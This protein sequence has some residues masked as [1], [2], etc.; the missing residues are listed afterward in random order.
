MATRTSAVQSTT[1]PNTSSALPRPKKTSSAPSF[2]QGGLAS[3]QAASSLL[4][5]AERFP[6][7]GESRAFLNL[8]AELVA[9]SKGGANPIS[10]GAGS[11]EDLFADISYLGRTLGSFGQ[12][13]AV[14]QAIGITTGENA[15]MGFYAA[16]KAGKRYRAAERI[17]DFGGKLEGGLD[18]ARGV[19]QGI[20][21][22]FYLGYRG[23]MIASEIANVDAT[24]S[25]TT[26]LGK[27]TFIIGVIGNIFFTVFYLF[28]GLWG[29][30]QLYRTRKM[31]AQIDQNSNVSELASFLL[32]KAHADTHVQLDKVRAMGPKRQKL[33]K[34]EL[35]EKCLNAFADQFILW[36]EKLKG[37][38]KLAEDDALVHFQMKDLVQEFFDQIDQDPGAKRA[39]LEHYCEQLGLDPD[40]IADLNFSSA[41]ICGLKLEEKDRQMR[42]EAR[43]G[44][45]MGGRAVQEIKDAHRKGLGERLLS[46]NLDVQNAA[47]AEAAALEETVRSSLVKNSLIY[48]DLLLIGV[49]G[50][51]VSVALIGFFA[52]PPG[53]A[54]AMTGLSIVLI[55][56]MMGVD[57]YSWLSGLESEAPG[58]HDKL[59]VGGITTVLVGALVLAACLTFVGVGF[60]LMPFIFTMAIGIAGLGVC[61]YTLVKLHL[62]EK[63]WKEEHPDLERFAEKL[64]N[65]GLDRQDQRLDERTA[66]LFKKL[67]KGDRLAIRKEYLAKKTELNFSAA[68]IATYIEGAL[69]RDPTAEADQVSAE[70]RVLERAAKKTAKAFWDK[71]HHSHQKIDQQRALKMY[72]LIEALKVQGEEALSRQRLIMKSIQEDPTLYEAF[73]ENVFYV[74][75]REESAQDLKNVVDSVRGAS[76][77]ASQGDSRSRA[78]SLPDDCL[79]RVQKILQIYLDASVWQCIA[80]QR[81]VNF[82]CIEFFSPF[83]RFSILGIMSA[84]PR[85]CCAEE[86]A[87]CACGLLLTPWALKD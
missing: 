82:F 43:L 34:E 31:V 11:A 20:G 65:L 56:A 12:S 71:W 52:L 19:A 68:Y 1:G 60:P 25:A 76:Q 29:G 53:W 13:S 16:F 14:Y 57:G 22:A 58:K 62:R 80:K 50:V 27:T 74:S 2:F 63:K 18:V 9:L 85:L 44:R 30:Y 67:S 83:F 38:G 70:Y 46:N 40:A 79:E 49:L 78:P 10:G 42:K 3:G 17:G 8:L 61:I 7:P 54:L 47:K 64:D 15:F 81:R 77:A 48:F 39:Y 28:L 84:G 32:A 69:S 23:T 59:F 4:G 6:T 21:G 66:A 24:M 35:S 55:L 26:T 36:Q 73:K 5:H 75:K 87:V 72:E 51:I 86:K 33:Y 45:V 41:Q 37:E